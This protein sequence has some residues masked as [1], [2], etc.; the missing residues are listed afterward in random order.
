MGQEMKFV[1]CD[2]DEA[3]AAVEQAAET[4][5]VNEQELGAISSHRPHAV[6]HRPDSISHD[7][8]EDITRRS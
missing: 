3:R 8:H 5:T 2:D 4:S 1:R 7:D 6:F